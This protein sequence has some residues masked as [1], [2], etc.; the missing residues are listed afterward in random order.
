MIDVTH[1]LGALIT[2]SA[3]IGRAASRRY[4][5]SLTR[6]RTSS[7]ASATRSASWSTTKA[8]G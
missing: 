5:R 7:R 1:W 4:A 6:P 3:I 8:G 2:S